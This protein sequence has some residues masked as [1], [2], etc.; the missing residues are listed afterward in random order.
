MVTGFFVL[1]AEMRSQVY[2]NLITTSM[3]DGRISAVAGL[4]FSCRQIYDEMN[5]DCISKVRAILESIKAWS[6]KQQEGAL[7]LVQLPLGYDFVKRP[8]EALLSIP[9][10]RPKP[11]SYCADVSRWLAPSAAALNAIMN[12][13]WSRFTLC[14]HYLSEKGKGPENAYRDFK[15]HQWA[16]YL[17]FASSF[18]SRT[19]LE[20]PMS[21][22]T[23][24]IRLGIRRGGETRPIKKLVED[25]ARS[26]LRGIRRFEGLRSDNELPKSLT[27]RIVEGW[28]IWDITIQREE[29]ISND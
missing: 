3:A 6:D 24:V 19:G 29:M 4:L 1:S 17:L 23:L 16:L 26:I 12:H 27:C 7:L 2:G 25:E 21:T 9:V 20:L 22:D 28:E 13:P 10:P 14:T 11:A 15:Q 18:I 5:T 8:A